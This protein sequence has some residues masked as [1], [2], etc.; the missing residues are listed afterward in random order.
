MGDQILNTQ[1]SV[2][3]VTEKIDDGFNND[4][5][6]L[7]DSFWIKKYKIKDAKLVLSRY[8]PKSIQ[9]NVFQ[10]N[11][12]FR[13]FLLLLFLADGNPSSEGKDRIAN[14]SSVES[15]SCKKATTTK[16]LINM[17]ESNLKIFVYDMFLILFFLMIFDN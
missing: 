2:D 7:S 10:L 14:I 1:Q 8:E 3:F 5:T 11:K 4:A 17:W 13:V 6:K 12:F 9:S 15:I 16:P